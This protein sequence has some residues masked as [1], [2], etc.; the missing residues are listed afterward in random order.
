MAWLDAVQFNA[1][2]LVPV[3]AQDAGDQTILM[4]AW[5]NAEALSLTVE[6][7]QVVY[8]S[9][10][11]Q[12]LWRKGESSGNVQQLRD[13]YLDC[14]GDVLVVSVE[15]IG[16]VACHTGRK[17]CFFKKLEEGS[18]QDTLPVLKSPSAMYGKKE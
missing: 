16:G 13:M 15:Q 7:G 12:R 9:R 5:M 11:R 1:D 14:D 4:M 17:S 6:T 3:I 10:S 8:Y 2:G 18:W